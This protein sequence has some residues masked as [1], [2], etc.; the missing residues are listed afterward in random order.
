MAIADD[1][2]I[3][4]TSA[5]RRVGPDLSN[6]LMLNPVWCAVPLGPYPNTVEHLYQMFKYRLLTELT[7]GSPA[8]AADIDGR[9]RDWLGRP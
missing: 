3:Q 4:Q 2:H 1:F 5:P 9:I 7:E 8:Q 6:I